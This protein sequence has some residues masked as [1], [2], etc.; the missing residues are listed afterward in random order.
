MTKNRNSVLLYNFFWTQNTLPS[1]KLSLE[2][3]YGLYYFN[4]DFS[5]LEV[6]LAANPYPQHLPC[7]KNIGFN[8]KVGSSAVN[9]KI[10]LKSKASL[11]PG[12][13]FWLG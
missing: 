6:V 9:D 2:A 11:I 10:F 4:Q 13:H 5:G 1:H 12:I 3:I 8:K 7:L